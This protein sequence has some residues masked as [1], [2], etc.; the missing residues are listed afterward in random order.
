MLFPAKCD[1]YLCGESIAITRQEF[2]DFIFDKTVFKDDFVFLVIVNSTINKSFLVYA[3][4]ISDALEF[5]R[6]FLNI[7]EV[8]D[9][10]VH[11]VKL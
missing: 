10:K 4:Q 6:E 5:I 1:H 9:Y 2:S 3:K 11:E 7:D 8:R